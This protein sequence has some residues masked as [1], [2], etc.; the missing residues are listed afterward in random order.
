[1][2]VRI[3]DL[4]QPHVDGV[5]EVVDVTPPHV[6][7]EP[8]L[9]LPPAVAYRRSSLD[10]VLDAG[11]RRGPR[12]L[13]VAFAQPVAPGREPLDRVLALLDLLD[14][15]GRALLL[16]GDEHEDL[17]AAALLG[18][19]GTARVQVRRLLPLDYGL[20]R[21]AAL[22]ERTDAPLPLLPPLRPA[23][24]EG[25]RPDD[26]ATTL[27]LSNER[28][29]LAFQLRALRTTAP[30]PTADGRH[31]ATVADSAS[32]LRIEQ[33]TTERQQLEGAHRAAEQELGVAQ[34]RVAALE[35]SP[36]YQIGRAL[37]QAAKQPGPG[38]LRLPKRLWSL[39]QA[40]ARGSG[41]ATVAPVRTTTVRPG[42]EHTLLHAH[43]A[44]RLEPR[45]GLGLAGVWTTAT[46]GRLAPDCRTAT[47]L[48]DDAA[49]TLE[50]VRPDAV[51]IQA[52]A[53]RAGQP[54]AYA[55]TTVGLQRDVQLRDL[56]ASARGLD[57]PVVLWMDVPSHEAGALRDLA[58][59][60]DLVVGEPGAGGATLAFHAGLQ[61]ATH[62]PVDL[63]PARPPHALHV[64]ARDRRARP[65]DRALVDELLRAVAPAG[66]A[67]HEDPA[68]PDD[69]AWPDD[70]APHTTGPLPWRRSAA[71]YRRA[72]LA[73]TGPARTG[74]AT[75]R[76][77]EQLACGARLVG[78]PD[79][80]LEAL[81][82][83]AL[84]VVAPADADGAVA[85]LVAAGPP[86]TADVRRRL[87]RL[88]PEHGTRN[89]LAALARALGLPTS[90][91]AD[92][93]VAVAVAVDP[94]RPLADLVG[95][96][97]AQRHR[98]AEVLVA[99]GATGDAARVAR[100][101]E[102]LRGA[103]LT[104]QVLVVS[105][106]DPLRRLR[107]LSRAAASPW[108]AC[109]SQEGLRHAWALTDAVVAVE[110]SRADAVGPVG[111][112]DD[113][114]FVD[115]LPVVGSLL[116]RAPAA[117]DGLPL[118]DGLR[119]WHRRGLRLFGVTDLP[120]EPPTALVP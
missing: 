95:A 32:Q 4:L 84:T 107:Q 69:V 8:Y 66:L 112:I 7:V 72:T 30:Q 43:T 59:S 21:S 113:G 54:W 55:G 3:V 104:V 96:V 110:C 40:R 22:V 70:L 83:D 93:D 81:L 92:L 73:V 89:Q 63:D 88:W 99:V 25:P 65:G 42:R 37:I 115:G 75:A 119:H 71:A 76:A 91:A 17:P 105:E 100:G 62:H 114:T 34:Q 87:R 28:E 29:V 67:V 60:C 27:R 16:F 57:V 64:G 13:L 24:A 44:A 20:V 31:E 48:P 46:A 52:A 23:L 68:A 77:L 79:P 109:W 45:R 19:L 94:D 5:A 49:L 41:G 120:D 116:R 2:T 80:V 103:G 106:L 102:E 26:A 36:A 11:A 12:D 61:L 18:A 101:M 82:R 35:R 118:D 117:D 90:P 47:L 50:R 1:M 85:R 39:Y 98:P 86:S 14:V 53:V 33:L 51:L 38:T 58:P 6:D 97:L 108:I 78:V 15:G 74:E 56:V 9:A 111:A 10:E